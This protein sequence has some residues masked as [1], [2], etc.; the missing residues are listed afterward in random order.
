MLGPFL[1]CGTAIECAG[2]RSP[3]AYKK[4]NVCQP[5]NDFGYIREINLLLE[6]QKDY[7]SDAR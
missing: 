3:L 4:Q 5:A 1:R 6:M 2:R 7:S